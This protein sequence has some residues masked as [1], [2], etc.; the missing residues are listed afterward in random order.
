MECQ[1][2]PDSAYIGN[3]LQIGVHLLIA[4]N[5]KDA[6]G[7]AINWIILVLFGYRQGW[8]QKGNFAGECVQVAIDLLSNSTTDFFSASLSCIK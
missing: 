3:F 5:R 1:V 6:T 2:L 4:Q 8:R 7:M